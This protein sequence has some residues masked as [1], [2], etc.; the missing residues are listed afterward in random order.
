MSCGLGPP[1]ALAPTE[2]LAYTEGFVTAIPY[3]PQAPDLGLLAD[4]ETWP[5]AIS[6]LSHAGENYNRLPPGSVQD[7]VL[8][9][10]H[11]AVCG[12]MPKDR[13]DSLTAWINTLLD[14][15]KKS[16]TADAAV[17]QVKLYLGSRTGWLNAV[18]DEIGK[19]AK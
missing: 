14:L 15:T 18:M 1:F 16:G 19:C 12:S 10:I 2:A 6:E 13:R 11:S 9:R 4:R 3:L 8:A 17:E 7:A 5:A